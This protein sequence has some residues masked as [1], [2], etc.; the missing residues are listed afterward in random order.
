MIVGVQELTMTR[1]YYSLGCVH[2]LRTGRSQVVF[3]AWRVACG[4]RIR[5][6]RPVVKEI[7]H[8]AR[9]V[10]SSVAGRGLARDPVLRSPGSGAVANPGSEAYRRATAPSGSGRCAWAGRA[11]S[12]P[13]Q[14]GGSWRLQAPLA[15]HGQRQADGGVDC[16]RRRLL[17]RLEPGA[18]GRLAVRAGVLL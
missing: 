8:D 6:T 2:R 3:S 12:A 17:I 15:R 5:P 18:T 16:R 10:T 1:L 14:I 11:L 9:D 13:R 4:R 7:D